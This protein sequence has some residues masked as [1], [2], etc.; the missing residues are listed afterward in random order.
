VSTIE[1]LL[2]RKCSC[3]LETREYG[4]GDPLCWSRNIFYPQKLA[5][6]SPISGSLLVSIVHSRTKAVDF[7]FMYVV[8]VAQT[9]AHGEL[10]KISRACT[11]PRQIICLHHAV[12]LA[13]QSIKCP[14]NGYLLYTVCD[15]SYSLSHHASNLCVLTVIIFIVCILLCITTGSSTQVLN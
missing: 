14:L 11:E 3:I 2:G 10:H 9:R 13:D 1:V 12:M 8:E 7:H 5:L 15:S 4:C 6:T